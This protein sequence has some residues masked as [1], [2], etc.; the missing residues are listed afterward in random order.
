MVHFGFHIKTSTV[1]LWVL[2]DLARHPK[3]QEKMYEEVTSLIG[4]HGDFTPT[5]FSKLNY[6]K[7]CIKESLR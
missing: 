3:V 7:A 6:I 5:S 2:Y 4:P 1:T